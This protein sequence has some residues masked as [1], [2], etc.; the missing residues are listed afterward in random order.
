[1]NSIPQADKTDNNDQETGRLPGLLSASAPRGPGLDSVE[2][3]IGE[4]DVS[5]VH[6]FLAQPQTL[7]EAL[8]VDDLPLAQEADGV[9]HVRVV[10]QPQDV[11]VGETGLLL[12]CDLVRTTFSGK[13]K[14][15]EKG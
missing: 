5:G 12:W 4:I 13:G 10:G 1:M 15:Q 6:F 7:A 3:R 11:V 2:R 8:E 9:V 14:A